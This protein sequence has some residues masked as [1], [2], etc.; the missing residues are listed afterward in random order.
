MTTYAWC[1]SEKQV[2][3]LL[4]RSRS[5]DL[6][7]ARFVAVLPEAAWALRERGVIYD[8]LEDFYCERS[9]CQLAE[10]LLAREIEWADSVDTWLQHRLPMWGE[11]GFCPARLTLYYLKI[12]F[13]ELALRTNVLKSFIDQSKARRIIYYAAPRNS[14]LEWHVGFNESVYRLLLPHFADADVELVGLPAL[15]GDHYISWGGYAPANSVRNRFR[16]LWERMPRAWRDR[17]RPLVRRSLGE[18]SYNADEAKICIGHGYDLEAIRRE[19]LGSSVPFIDW[20]ELMRRVTRARH[21]EQV[22]TVPRGIWEELK[23]RKSFWELAKP[24]GVDLRSLA[25]PRLA[26]WWNDGVLP[27][28]S[29]FDAALKVLPRE[30]LSAILTP[31]LSSP[32][33]RGVQAAA[34]AV[35]IPVALFQHGGFVAN[36]EHVGWDVDDLALAD[37]SFVYGDGV[38]RYFEERRQRSSKPLATPVAVG[39]PRLDAIRVAGPRRRA[40]IRRRLTNGKEGPVVLYVPTAFMAHCR[41][42]VCDV[43]PDV[44]YFELQTRIFEA[45]AKHPDVRFVYK[46]FVSVV[47]HPMHAALTRLCPEARWVTSSPLTDLIWAADAIIVDFPSTALLEA[48]L[49]SAPIILYADRESVRLRDEARTYLDRRVVLTETPGRFL[50]A[51]CEL[52]TNGPTSALRSLDRD[53]EYAY[54]THKGDGKSAAA[55]LAALLEIGRRR[56]LGS[57]VARKAL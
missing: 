56:R 27:M 2:K 40:Q 11:S 21:R 15:S 1:E 42:L 22:P 47:R 12:F 36:C 7:T 48:I 44:P 9:L 5:E 54:A 6:A 35:G 3:Q 52:L 25:E 23:E 49:T 37:F 14:K 18:M 20:F 8:R 4:E 33:A 26:A 57:S 29:A 50:E 39:S 46:A 17:L 10:P 41:Q 24:E 31:T 34:R 30:R 51:I 13:D 55:A 19:A 43:Y 53:F 45:F 32:E 16:R 28:W 38:A